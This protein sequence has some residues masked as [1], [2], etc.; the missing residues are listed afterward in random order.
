MEERAARGV[1]ERL[2]SCALRALSANETGE[3]ASPFSAPF[4][5]WRIIMRTGKRESSSGKKSIVVH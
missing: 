4:T 2:I 1:R 3:S 5:I